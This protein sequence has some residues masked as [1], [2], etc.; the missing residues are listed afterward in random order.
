V[1]LWSEVHVRADRL[2]EV[3]QP[4]GAEPELLLVHPFILSGAG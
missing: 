1:R 3:A 2:S 4:A